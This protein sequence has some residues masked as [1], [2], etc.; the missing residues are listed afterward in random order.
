MPLPGNRGFAKA[1]LSIIDTSL[2]TLKYSLF[3][4]KIMMYSFDTL[5]LTVWAS[6]G[7]QYLN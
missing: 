3:W 4:I 5:E 2:D 7:S 6:S 1:R